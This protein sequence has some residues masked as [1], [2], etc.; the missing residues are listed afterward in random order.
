MREIFFIRIILHIDADEDLFIDRHDLDGV[1]DGAEGARLDIG[2]R[3]LKMHVDQF[4]YQILP[5]GL[6]AFCKV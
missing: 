2:I 3:P 1:A 6:F 4:L 5:S